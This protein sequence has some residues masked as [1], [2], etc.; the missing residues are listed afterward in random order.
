MGAHKMNRMA[1]ALEFL[2]QYHKDGYEFLNHIIQ[3][4][5]DK[6]WVAF[7]NAETKER[8]PKQWMHSFT[9]HAKK[10]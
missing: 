8:Q 1:S 2:Y 4:T 6:V 9:K 7:V 5:G 10:V 3:V